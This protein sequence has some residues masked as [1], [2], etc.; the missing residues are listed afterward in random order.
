[1]KQILPNFL[2]AIQSLRKI[3]PISIYIWKIVTFSKS[4]ASSFA[5]FNGLG[6]LLLVPA[7]IY[8]S[9][10]NFTSIAFARDLGDENVATLALI[11]NFHNE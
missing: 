9:H 6:A 10:F 3:R 5:K 4:L 11:T 8:G 1:V 7:I 2:V